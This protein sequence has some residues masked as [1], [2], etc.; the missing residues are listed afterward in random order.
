MSADAL[1]AFGPIVAAEVAD[2][3]RPQGDAL[4]LRLLVDTGAELTV[5]PRDVIDALG[6]QLVR[7][8]EIT[9]VVRGAVARC[10]VFRVVLHVSG[11]A[12]EVEVAAVERDAEAPD[13]LLGRDILSHLDFTYRGPRGSFTLEHG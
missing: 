1:R 4:P 9:G 2:P 13:G 7:E 8:I 12:F 3:D 10:P 6:R 5:I 11:V